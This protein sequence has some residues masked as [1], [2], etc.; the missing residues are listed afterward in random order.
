MFDGMKVKFEKERRKTTLAEVAEVLEGV[1]DGVIEFTG[2]AGCAVGAVVK[3]AASVR[4]VRAARRG[5]RAS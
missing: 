5:R 3:A 4:A 1:E 2:D